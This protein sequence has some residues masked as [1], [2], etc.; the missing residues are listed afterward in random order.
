MRSDREPSSQISKR[1]GTKPGT[2]T[3]RRGT[4]EVNSLKTKSGPGRIRTL[5]KFQ[6]LTAIEKLQRIQTNGDG[7]T[8]TLRA[9]KNQASSEHAYTLEEVADMLDKLLEPAPTVC[10]VAV[11]TGL[12]R[13]ELCGLKWTDYDGETIMVQRKV[14]KVISEHQ[15]LRLVRLGCTSFRCSERFWRNTK[16]HSHHKVTAGFSGEKDCCGPGPGRYGEAGYSTAH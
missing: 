11:F 12:T 7:D 1:Q 3:R 15:K 5:D 2:L 14:G 9:L 4:A 13:S 10:A 16:P 8:E 6:G